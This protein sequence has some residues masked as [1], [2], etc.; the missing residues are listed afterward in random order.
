M[1]VL[2]FGVR[3]NGQP[4]EI[5]HRDLASRNVLLEIDH[6]QIIRLSHEFTVTLQEQES[7]ILEWPD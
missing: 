4:K 3:I 2:H 5:I 1:A 6:G 7:V